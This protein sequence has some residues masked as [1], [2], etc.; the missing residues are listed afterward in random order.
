MRFIVWITLLCVSPFSNLGMANVDVQ[1]LALQRSYLKTIDCRA[2]QQL[3]NALKQSLKEDNNL[4]ARGHYASVFEEIMM[5]NPVCF[6]QALK[7][8]PKRTCQRFAADY[9]DETFF[10]P[11]SAIKESLSSAKDYPESCIAG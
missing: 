2:P 8:L 7:A 10:Y 5:H 3:T 6:V 11:R 9:I 1:T 4:R